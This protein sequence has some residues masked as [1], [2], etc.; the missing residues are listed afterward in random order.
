M[1]LFGQ[2]KSVIASIIRVFPQRHNHSLRI[3]LKISGILEG[4]EYHGVAH[5]MKSESK[6][7][8]EHE[9]NSKNNAISASQSGRV[10]INKKLILLE[11]LES[12]SIQPRA[13]MRETPKA[14]FASSSRWVLRIDSN[15]GEKSERLGL[16]KIITLNEWLAGRALWPSSVARLSLA[17]LVI[18]LATGASLDAFVAAEES[19]DHGTITTT[20][21]STSSII[22]LPTATR[23]PRVREVVSRGDWG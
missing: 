12:R 22:D 3:T 4:Q 7:P 5:V 15:P 13:D 23:V 17:A 1:R 10:T 9:G 20:L 21:S 18:S 2:M 6:Y 19:R 8:R 14:P 11:D 16:W